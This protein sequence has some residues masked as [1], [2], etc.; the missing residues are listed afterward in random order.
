MKKPKHTFGPTTGDQ[1]LK[2]RHKTIKQHIHTYLKYELRNYS[3]PIRSE[4]A[5]G[6]V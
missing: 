5:S 3:K 1:G 4:Q 2:Q 6:R